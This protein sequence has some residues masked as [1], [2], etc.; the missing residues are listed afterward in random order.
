[1][2]LGKN[3]FLGLNNTL[4]NINSGIDGLF[5]VVERENINSTIEVIREILS[6]Q[7]TI[8]IIKGTNK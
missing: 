5:K 2:E 4:D 7:P 8:S 1:M 3:E 6:H